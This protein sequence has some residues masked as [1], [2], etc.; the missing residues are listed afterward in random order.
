MEEHAQQQHEAA[1]VKNILLSK[2]D[3][4]AERLLE[5]VTAQVSASAPS[6]LSADEKSVFV[7]RA[8]Q[9]RLQEI[10]ASLAFKLG[11]LTKVI[12]EQSNNQVLEDSFASI[13]VPGMSKAEKSLIYRRMFAAMVDNDTCV[14]FAVTNQ[15]LLGN[16]RARDVYVLSLFI[17]VTCRRCKSDDLGML[18]LSGRSSVGKSRL[19]E[20]IILPTCHQLLSSSGSSDAGCGRF[21]TGNRNCVLLHDIPVKHLVSADC[22]RIK[23]ICRAETTVAKIHSSTVTLQPLFLFAT[24]NER[25]LRHSVPST[26]GPSRMPICLPS[27]MND[28]ASAGGR[29]KRLHPENV[30]AVQNRFI[31]MYVRARPVQDEADLQNS[32]NFDRENFILAV[33][34][35]VL[36]RMEHYQL[37]D[38]PSKYF[39]AYVMAALDRNLNLYLQ[40]FGEHDDNDDDNISSQLIKLH[41]KYKV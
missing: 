21:D 3:L 34:P 2:K 31:E 9:N 10:S 41:E 16:M 29:G 18:F 27:Q 15:R 24:S 14:S 4:A 1:N 39:Y 32:D 5:N 12:V 28:G 6:H 8:T 7:L 11:P 38:F 17:F 40:E 30:L 19:F 23:T 36:D 13:Q 35:R 33:F 25:L 20:N 26:R 37:S 22:E